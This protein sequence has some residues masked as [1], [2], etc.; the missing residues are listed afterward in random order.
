MSDA[1][2]VAGKIVGNLMLYGSIVAEWFADT[3]LQEVTVWCAILGLALQFAVSIP[4]L[5]ESHRTVVL[6]IQSI[7]P[8]RRTR[9]SR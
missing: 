7:R 2:R 1:N 8:G 6:I 3:S 9:K 4:K 5:V